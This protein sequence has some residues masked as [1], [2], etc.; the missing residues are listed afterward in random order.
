MRYYIRLMNPHP[1]PCNLCP[2]ASDTMCAQGKPA[3]ESVSGGLQHAALTAV[4]FRGK[5]RE[6]EEEAGRYFLLASYGDPWAQR[7]LIVHELAGLNDSVGVVATD[8]LWPITKGLPAIA[9]RGW[10]FST[11]KQLRNKLLS[12]CSQELQRSGR[13]RGRERETPACSREQS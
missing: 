3:I 7:A 5:I 4:R 12:S 2:N 10:K 13:E 1:T 9:T 11:R 8:G 6:G